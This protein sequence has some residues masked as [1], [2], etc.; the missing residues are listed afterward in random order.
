MGTGVGARG[1]AGG[2]RADAVL[3]RLRTAGGRCTLK[4]GVSGRHCCCCC[5]ISGPV[6]GLVLLG[7]VG[8]GSEGRSPGETRRVS[9]ERLREGTGGG[10][11][12]AEAKGDGVEDEEEEEG[13]GEESRACSSD[14]LAD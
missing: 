4:S 2:V 3:W 12:R 10:G 14:R 11:S 8:S 13:E 5:C 9:W 7:R 6:K 1:A